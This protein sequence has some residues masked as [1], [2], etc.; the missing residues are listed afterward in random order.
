M[1]C[2]QSDLV[3]YF[4]NGVVIYAAYEQRTINYFVSLHYILLRFYAF[5]QPPAKQ[6]YPTT[7]LFCG[8]SFGKFY[9]VQHS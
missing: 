7:L 3:V 4:A 8:H 9:W 6:R 1:S 5:K 2:K